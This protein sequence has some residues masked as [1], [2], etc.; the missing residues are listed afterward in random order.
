LSALRSTKWK[1]SNDGVT[2]SLRAGLP[3]DPSLGCPRD[4]DAG[5]AEIVDIIFLEV[6]KV[7][8]GRRVGAA[9]V[10]PKVRVGSK[11][12]VPSTTEHSRSTF[13]S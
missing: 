13:N 5:A 9:R 7:G 2:F 3:L 8:E 11:S 10:S 4:V 6:G 1:P 12:T